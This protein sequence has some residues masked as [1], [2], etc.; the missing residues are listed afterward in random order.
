MYFCV[1]EFEVGI[2][3]SIFS[4]NEQ[5]M[6]YII[7]RLQSSMGQTAKITVTN[8]DKHF[9]VYPIH[10]TVVVL[11]ET[12]PIRFSRLKD[13]VSSQSGKTCFSRLN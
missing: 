2:N 12:S 3:D 1:T 8:S 4:G 7:G 13:D 5:Q 10:N 9:D 6:V 11:H